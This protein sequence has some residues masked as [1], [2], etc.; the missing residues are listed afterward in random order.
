[1]KT[2]TVQEKSEQVFF[3]QPKVHQFKFVE[4]NKTV[5]MDLLKLISFFKECQAANKAAGILEKIAKDKRSHKK[6]GGASSCC[7]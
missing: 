1:M 7:A 4:T 2:P 3:V 5:P 6:K